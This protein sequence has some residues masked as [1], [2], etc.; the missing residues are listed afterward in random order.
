M[1]SNSLTLLFQGDSITDA[2]RNREQAEANNFA[3]LGGGYAMMAATGIL[4]D[5]AQRTPRIYNR[6]NSGDR[7]VDLYARWKIDA[8]NLR[9]DIISI[10]IGVND[11]WHEFGG[12]NGVE[13]SRYQTIYRL[14]LEWTRSI[15]PD[16]QLVLC[17]PFLLPCGVV[18]P[19]WREEVD[20]RRKVVAELAQQF[21]ALL[22][23]F[24]TLFDTA[25]TEAPAE[26]WAHDGVHP[27]PAGHA[28]MAKCWR[29][30]VGL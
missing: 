16:A 11:T 4:A 24:Q 21:N 28:R 18:G 6:G 19:G 9:P 13:V 20:Q 26:Y 1:S 29:E 3:G 30:C 8:L 25:L 17:E 7:V 5:H 22:V 14:L 27:T 12:N 10:L 15:L 2:G 23:P